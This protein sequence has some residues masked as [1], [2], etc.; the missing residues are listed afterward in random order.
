[1]FSL[2]Y[3]EKLLMIYENEMEWLFFQHIF[4]FAVRSFGEKLSLS[5]T[6][7][8]SLIVIHLLRKLPLLLVQFT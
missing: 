5:V 3:Y 6:L 7:L 2:E 8:M 4:F 1:M